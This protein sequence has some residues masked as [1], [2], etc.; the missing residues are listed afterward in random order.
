MA[1]LIKGVM[2]RVQNLD[3]RFGTHPEYI[4]VKVDREGLGQQEEVL[5][6]TD[7]DL[8]TARKRAERSPKT[9]AA[10]ATGWLRNIF[11]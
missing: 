6:L 3:L 1:G 8:E 2:R 11:D 10:N 4:A 5:L 7:A 9:L